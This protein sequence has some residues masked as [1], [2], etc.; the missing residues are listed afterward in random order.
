MNKLINKWTNLLINHYVNQSIKTINISYIRLT[1]QS[2]NP[3]I[4]SSIDQIFNPL[5]IK[6]SN[7]HSI[8]TNHAI[9]HK[10][11]FLVINSLEHSII[12][13]T[14]H[15]SHPIHKHPERMTSQEWHSFLQGITINQN[16]QQ[17]EKLDLSDTKS[18]K[19]R[20]KIKQKQNM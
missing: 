17:Y 9:D 4:K 16:W 18:E 20:T 5:K 11:N 10:V 19:K 15:S 3:Q 1:N 14:N 13:I 7:N 6:H 2:F 12:L 8:N